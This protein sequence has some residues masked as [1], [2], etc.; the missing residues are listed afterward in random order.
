MNNKRKIKRLFNR[1]ID[2][3]YIACKGISKSWKEQKVSIG[4]LKHVIDKYKLGDKAELPE[5]FK[6]NYNKTLDLL[7]KTAREQSVGNAVSFS[8]LKQD[9]EI[10]KRSFAKGLDGNLN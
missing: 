10:I 7:L 9:I 5:K 1:H 8:N 4:V 2:N 6:E 3:I